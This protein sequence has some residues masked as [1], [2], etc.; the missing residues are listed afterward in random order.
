MISAAVEHYEQLEVNKLRPVLIPEPNVFYPFFDDGSVGAS[1]MRSTCSG[2]N[3]SPRR[4]GSCEVL[5]DLDFKNRPVAETE[6]LDIAKRSQGNIGG[7]GCCFAVH[8]WAHTWLGQVSSFEATFDVREMVEEEQKK[9]LYGLI[10]PWCCVV[11]VIHGN[12]NY[13]SL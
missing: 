11:S 3:L 1:N 4:A 13:G 10:V 12:L 8:H 2:E 6:K 5:Q 7:V 9:V